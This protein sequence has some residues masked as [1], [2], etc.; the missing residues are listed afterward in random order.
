MRSYVPA[1]AA[2]IALAWC[3]CA[4]TPHPGRAADAASMPPLDDGAPAGDAGAGSPDA[5]P[6]DAA[7]ADA[8]PTDVAVAA[9]LAATAADAQSRGGK[10]ALPP[11]KLKLPC[12]SNPLKISVPAGGGADPFK[13]EIKIPPDRDACILMPNKPLAQSINIIGGRNVRIVGGHIIAKPN[14]KLSGCTNFY[15]PTTSLKG[16]VRLTGFSKTFAIDGM[17]IDVNG[18][19]ADA[20]HFRNGDAPLAALKTRDIYLRNMLVRG[21]TGIHDGVHADILHNQGKAHDVHIENL[22]AH[23]GQNTLTLYTSETS[24]KVAL[25]NYSLG[26]DQR[27]F[28]GTLPCIPKQ[29]G[30]RSCTPTACTHT[31]LPVSFDGA[32][33]ESGTI[34]TDKG[35]FKP[36]AL[37]GT[38]QGLPPGGHFVGAKD[39]GIGYLPP[40]GSPCGC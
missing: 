8:W 17:H 16:V 38:H 15:C 1:I 20:I 35:K 7:R 3:A 39:V 25:R 18:N 11:N 31:S 10:S 27:F 22:S 26:K 32:Y 23:S 9:D 21:F 12:L 34:I 6:L 29:K 36:G 19:H 24:G 4:E 2:V 40:G 28:D 14:P 13:Y 33:C 37:P 5:S 30:I